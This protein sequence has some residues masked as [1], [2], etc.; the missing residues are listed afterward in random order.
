MNDKTLMGENITE[1]WAKDPWVREFME[2]VYDMFGMPVCTDDCY[3]KTDK[4]LHVWAMMTL[5]QEMKISNS[6]FEMKE[7]MDAEDAAYLF[8]EDNFKKSGRLL[9]QNIIEDDPI[10]NKFGDNNEI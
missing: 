10:N 4:I 2:E 7:T 6:W 1:L 9:L 5:V 8:V 3:S